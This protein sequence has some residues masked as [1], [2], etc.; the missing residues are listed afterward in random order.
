MEMPQKAASAFLRRDL[1][2]NSRSC[3]A[4]KNGAAGYLTKSD[5]SKRVQKNH[6]AAW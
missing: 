4:E 5:P 6:A 3:T 2:Y 1:F